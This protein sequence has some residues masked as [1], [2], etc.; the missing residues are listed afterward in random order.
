MIM[1]ITKPILEKSTL[2]V[3]PPTSA[4]FSL[5]YDLSSWPYELDL[6]WVKLTT[7]PNIQGGPKIGTIFVRLN[8]TRY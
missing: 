6:D 4:T 2:E 8:F 7:L 5:T 1:P 3:A